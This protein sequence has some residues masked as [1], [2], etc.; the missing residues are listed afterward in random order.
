MRVNVTKSRWVRVATLREASDAVQAHLGKGGTRIG[1]SRWTGS[2]EVQDDNGKTIAV[3]SYNGRV[4]T[5][6]PWPTCT[7]INV[8]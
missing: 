1:A 7:E 4:W 3:V 5:P 6:E 2:G 8:F